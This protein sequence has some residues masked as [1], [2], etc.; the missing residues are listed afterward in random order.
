MSDVTSTH[1]EPPGCRLLLTPVGAGVTETANGSD[2]TPRWLRPAQVMVKTVEGK[3]IP[4]SAAH[5]VFD[6]LVIAA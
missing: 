2:Q 5:P 1:D 3:P 6:V 4:L